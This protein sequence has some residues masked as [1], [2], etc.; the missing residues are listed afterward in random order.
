[1]DLARPLLRVPSLAIHLDRGVNKD[2]LQLNPQKHLPPIL[3]LSDDAEVDLRAVLGEALGRGGVDAPAEDI[4]A[5]DLCCYDVQPATRS[6]L[7]GEFLHA[8]RLD[9]LASCH[10]AVTALAA[11]PEAGASTL[12]VVLYDHEEVGSR[13][14]QGAASSFLR[15]CLERV[16]GARSAAASDALPRAVAR[17]FMIS[18]DMAHA[19]HPNFADRH[20]P[21][22]QPILGKGPVVKINANQAYATDGVAWAA[23]E[24]WSR[25]VE[26]EPQ[27]FVVRTDLPCGSTIGPI[28]AAE[29]GLRVVDVGNPMLSMHSCREM[30]A[31]ADVPRMID[32]MGRFFRDAG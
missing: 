30:A 26:V 9:N 28:T 21:R 7:A 12:A 6:G 25:D 5:W 32:V 19:V 27:R 16:A 23:F 4:L 31:A 10:A 13:S 17:S 2:G 24:R 11:A 3:A 29:L 14:A 18:A 8:A 22:H 20:D 1:V 15:T